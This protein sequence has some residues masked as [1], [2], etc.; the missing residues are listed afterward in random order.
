MRHRRRYRC[1][2]PCGA[3]WDAL[4]LLEELLVLHF[5][6]LEGR[7]LLLEHL[8]PVALRALTLA[9][10]PFRPAASASALPARD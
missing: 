10:S 7:A 4:D 8:A 9:S 3:A 6:R 2:H 5:G 1:Q